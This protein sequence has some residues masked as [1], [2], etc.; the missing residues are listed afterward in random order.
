NS[1]DSRR[2]SGLNLSSSQTI[3]D[4]PLSDRTNS[5]FAATLFAKWKTQEFAYDQSGARHYRRLWYLRSAWSGEGA[6]E[7]DHK[8][9]GPAVGAVARRRDCRIAGR[10]SVTARPRSSSFAIRYQ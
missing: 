6:I 4:A 5:Q 7:D 9:V 10:V 8:S 1:R 2:P 3:F